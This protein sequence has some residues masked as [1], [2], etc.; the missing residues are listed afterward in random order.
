MNNLR[1]RA[2]KVFIGGISNGEYGLEAEDI[3]VM[4][5]GKGCKLW[6]TTGREFIDFSMAW[7]SCLVLIKKYFCC[8]LF[9][10]MFRLS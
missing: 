4:I 8:H 5:R 2:L 3:L 7:G 9:S 10:D 6:D 1:K